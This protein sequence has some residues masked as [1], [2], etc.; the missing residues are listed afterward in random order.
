MKIGVTGIIGSGKT[1]VATRLAELTGAVFINSDSL[2]RGFLQKDQAGWLA[3]K[4]KWRSRF[5][6]PTEEIDTA[7]LRKAVFSDDSL[8]GELESILHPLVKN[9]VLERFTDKELKN[10]LFVV[11][12]PLLF[13]VGWE[14]LFDQVIVVSTDEKDCIERTMQRDNV[15]YDQVLR[16]LN[17][18]I[19]LDVKKNLADVV[20]DNSGSLKNTDRQIQD[21]VEKRLALKIEVQKT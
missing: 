19:P 20:I 13:E 6:L 16:M 10:S 12:V 11:E 18:Q 21:F 17:A 14:S 2:V 7:L 8:R 1:S 5:L 9:E 15:S 4:K 3:I